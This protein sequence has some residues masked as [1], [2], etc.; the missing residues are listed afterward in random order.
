M[1]DSV[2]WGNG[3]RDDHKSAVLVASDLADETQRTVVLT[4]FAHSGAALAVPGDTV[5]I[6]P[7]DNG[8]PQ[9]DLNAT[10]PT[11]SE[12]ADCAAQTYGDAELVL[13]D[14]CINE[15]GA[16]NI[17][18][19]FTPTPTII[20]HTR[21]F[22]GIPMETLL[23]NVL[24]AFP[25]AII[26]VYDYFPIVSDHSSPFGL[27]R[28]ARKQL[29]AQRMSQ[30]SLPGAAPAQLPRRLE[31]TQLEAWKDNSAAFHQWSRTC[32]QWAIVASQVPAPAHQDGGATQLSVCDPSVPAGTQNASR[33]FLAS[34]SDDPQYAYGASNT[35]LW[36]LPIQFLWWTFR[37]D[38]L[39]KPRGKLC[40]SHYP[41][42]PGAQL[43]CEIN[44]IAHP[45]VTGAHAYYDSIIA[46]VRNAWK[47]ATAR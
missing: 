5:P 37:A 34:V 1:G 28:L 32:F 26:V 33:V 27:K 13:L 31:Q 18:F 16:T 42:D 10:S 39:Y 20:E 19:P 12:Q 2:V 15:V 25:H 23:R 44:P 47:P 17:A 3:D 43:I 11:T 45:N 30:E 8:Q 9:G 24:A 46:L 41:S 14:G 38:E 29:T 6:L 21:T 40:K 22:C 36:S 35:R 4:F 7:S